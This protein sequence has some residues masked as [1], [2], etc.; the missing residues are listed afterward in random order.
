M[1]QVEM[2][3]YNCCK[4]RWFAIDLKNKIYYACFLWDK[5][6][7]I[8]F[9]ISAENKMDPGELPAYCYERTRD[10]GTLG[11]IAT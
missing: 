8:P 2:E 1:N 4:E 9:F 5:G 6:K 11:S 10:P 3:T 7:K